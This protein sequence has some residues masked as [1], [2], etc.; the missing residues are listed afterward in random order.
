MPIKLRHTSRLRFA[1]RSLIEGVEC[2]DLPEYPNIE[3]ANDDI[4]YKLG[5]LDRIDNLAFRFYGS[6][7]LW[8]IIAL[9]NGFNLLPNDLKPYVY[10][11]IPSPRRVSTEILR[12]P[13]RGLEGR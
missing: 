6:K 3:A 11:K 9:R 12:H 5:K 7:D 4:T 10:I 1:K 13:T 2:W 8:W